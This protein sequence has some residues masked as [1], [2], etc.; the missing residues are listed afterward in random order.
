MSK[1]SIS[2]LLLLAMFAACKTTSTNPIEG[3]QLRLI[4]SDQDTTQIVSGPVTFTLTALQPTG[5]G[6]S[7][8]YIDFYDPIEK[9]ARHEGPT[10]EDG[11]WQFTD[12]IP[13]ALGGGVFE[14][15]F[16]AV[17]S[18][19]ITS[20]SLR[21]WVSAKDV[22][23][24]VI[25]SIA[26]NSMGEEHI[27]IQWSRPPIDS[28][29]DTI[30]VQT[31]SGLVLTPFI[32]PYPANNAEIFVSEVG[33]DTI[34]VHN[35]YASSPSIVWA[36]ANYYSGMEI[37]S[38]QDSSYDE[39]SAIY[40]AAGEAI[41]MN[42]DDGYRPDADLVLV[43][44][45]S[46]QMSGLTMVSPSVSALTGFL[47]GRTTKLYAPIPF[48]DSGS[49]LLELYYSADL[50]TYINGV[51]PVYQIPLPDSSQYSTAFIAVTEDGNYARVAVSPVTT[52]WEG[53]K[54]VTVALSYQPIVGLPYAGRG[55]KR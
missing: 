25:D 53:H 40:F 18:G 19:A 34:T 55:R 8:A 42:A 41:P 23:L 32:E 43:K 5:Y 45:P 36:P 37:Y 46:N 1:C 17:E 47:G 29:T 54:Y 24:W 52:D 15:A 49:N 11:E 31:S 48:I 3:Q 10:P 22:H 16:A 39:F 7:G 13:A 51:T 20:D 12:T 4:T 2:L 44:D 28:G 21:L 33:T 6:A 38:I 35:A 14:Y 26:A 9:R 50:S 27:G 30:L